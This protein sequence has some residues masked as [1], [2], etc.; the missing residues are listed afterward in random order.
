LIDLLAFYNEYQDMLG[1]DRRSSRE[2]KKRNPT[3]AS[4]KE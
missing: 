4:P 1:F 3:A 2:R